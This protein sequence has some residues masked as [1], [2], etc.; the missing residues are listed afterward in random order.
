MSDLIVIGY[1]DVATANQALN[2]VLTLNRDLVVQLNGIAI[3]SVD[4]KGKLDVETPHKITGQSAAS[5]AL[6]GTLLGVLFFVP[7]IGLAIGGAMGALFGKLNQNGIDQHFRGK[8]QSLLKPGTAA[9]VIMTSKITEDKFGEAMQPFGGE[10]L[11]TS[12]S[13]E[14]ERELAHDLTGT[15]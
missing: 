6:W 11:K 1:K 7:V 3:V 15:A 14:S 12:L 5:G 10:L 9:L 13:E 2:V 4:D 8:V